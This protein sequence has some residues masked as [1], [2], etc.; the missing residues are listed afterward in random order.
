MFHKRLIAGAAIALPIALLAACNGSAPEQAGDAASGKVLPGSI[1]DDM[2]P[3]D[4]ATSQPPLMAP[5]PGKVASGTG[6]AAPDDAPEAEA[7]ETP[8]AAATPDAAPI[9]SA[10]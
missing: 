2:L 9:P 1:T 10:T 4:T 3:Y 8:S 7:T 5:E 6:D